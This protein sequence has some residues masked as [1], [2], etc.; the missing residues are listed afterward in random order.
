[1]KGIPAWL[2]GSLTS[3]P[4]WLNTSG[5]VYNRVGFFRFMAGPLEG[6]KLGQRNNG[7]LQ[8]F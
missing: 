2:G 1:M 5:R 3:K 7:A 8:E 4:T 6:F